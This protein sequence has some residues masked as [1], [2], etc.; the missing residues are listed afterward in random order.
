MIWQGKIYKEPAYTTDAITSHALE[1]I[2][3]NRKKPFFL[4]LAYNAPYGLG[5]VVRKEHRNRHTAY[6]ADKP[7]NSFPR[8]KISRWLQQNRFAVNNVTSIRSYA[9]AVS[10]M[11]DG[12][13]LVMEKLKELGLDK[14]TLVVFSA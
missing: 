12:V 11:D 13:G 3:Q 1:F 5:Q 7:M 6:Y 10:G 14:N 2:E 4:Y 9:A 8:A